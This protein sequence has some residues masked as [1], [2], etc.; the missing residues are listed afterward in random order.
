M[1]MSHYESCGVCHRADCACA[2][3]ADDLVPAG[4]AKLD[5]FWVV[6][7]P[8]VSCEM[9]EVVFETS[10]FGLARYVRGCA[11]TG[12]RQDESISVHYDAI[13]AYN[14]AGDRVKRLE[15]HMAALN[16]K[17]QDARRDAMAVANAVDETALWA[18]LR[19]KVSLPAV[20]DMV[21]QDIEAGE[22][23]DIEGEALAERLRKH[24]AR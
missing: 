11:A 2:D 17:I 4:M 16:A 22:N 23:T 13:S 12:S 20:V 1:R 21:R 14:D 8:T 7:D 3:R 5:K 15:K 9:S 24:L 18:E 6:V 10:A 19:G